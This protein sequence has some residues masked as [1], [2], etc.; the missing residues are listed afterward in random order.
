MCVGACVPSVEGMNPKNFFRSPRPSSA[1]VGLTAVLIVVTGCGVVDDVA[2]GTS[3][4]SFANAQ[5]LE[6]DRGETLEWLPDDAQ[7]IVRVAST[8]SDSTESL[9]FE[10]ERGLSGCETVER[11]SAPTM[12]V[13]GGLDVYAVNDVALCGEWAIAQNDGDFYAWTPAA[14]SGAR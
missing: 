7:H 14:E 11:Q 1:F 4:S 13:P 10:S 6:Q 9:V 5:M 12:V 8:R 3:Q 2:H